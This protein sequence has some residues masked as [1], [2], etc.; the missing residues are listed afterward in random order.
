V[1][2]EQAGQRLAQEHVVVCQDD[3]APSHDF[4]AQFCNA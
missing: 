4:V 3:S 2:F 1:L